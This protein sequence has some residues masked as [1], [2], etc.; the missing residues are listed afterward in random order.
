M[1]PDHIGGVGILLAAGRSVRMQGRDKRW[2]PVGEVPMALRVAQV[3]AAVPFARRLAVVRPDDAALAREFAR[4]SFESLIN[5]DPDRGR[6][7]SLACAWSALSE[8]APVMVSVADLP[9][10]TV[11][12]LQDLWQR[13]CKMGPEAIL[14]PRYQGRWGHPRCLGRRHVAALMARG[15]RESVPAYLAANP[16]LIQF[17]NVKDP[18]VVRDVDTPDAYNA[19][20]RRWHHA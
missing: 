12:L 10:L 3:F 6:F 1:S 9:E 13:F 16:H 8:A 2:L 18:A 11:G 5:P 7:S 4:L 15:G 20:C 19:V 17:W 14:I